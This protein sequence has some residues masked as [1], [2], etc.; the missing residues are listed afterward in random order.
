MPTPAG[1]ARSLLVGGA[2]ILLVLSVAFWDTLQAQPSGTA[3]HHYA[4]IVLPLMAFLVFS[5]FVALD[6]RRHGWPRFSW[7]M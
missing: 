5:A 7:Q 6:V 2:S 4:H 3:I 1:L